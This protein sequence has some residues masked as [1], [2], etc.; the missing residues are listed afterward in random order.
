MPKRRI[1]SVKVCEIMLDLDGKDAVVRIKLDDG[2]WYEVIR[3]PYVQQLLHTVTEY[4]I[5]AKV[6][7][8][9]EAHTVKQEQEEQKRE[10]EYIC[11]GYIQQ[12]NK[13]RT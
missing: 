11:L 6:K 9:R 13:S 4:G 10:E 2:C 1:K 12:T 3:K 7:E 8:Q 5:E